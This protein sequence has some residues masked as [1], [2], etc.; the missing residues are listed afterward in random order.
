MDFTKK[1]TGNRNRLRPPLRQPD[2]EPSKESRDMD[3]LI[4]RMTMDGMM[5]LPGQEAREMIGV[6]LKTLKE[7]YEQNE[8]LKSLLLRQM[9]AT[10]QCLQCK[11]EI[12]GTNVII[13][14]VGGRIEN[15]DGVPTKVDGREQTSCP[16][17][18]GPVVKV[19]DPYQSKLLHQVK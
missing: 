12:P 17:C 18:K 4:K 16:H 9:A 6:D 14:I 13:T 11:R 1:N 10:W 2:Q 15:I 19:E 3:E 7:K 5:W 8:R